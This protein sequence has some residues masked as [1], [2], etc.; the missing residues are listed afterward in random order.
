VTLYGRNV[1]NEYATT[2]HVQ[3]VSD[4]VTRYVSDPRTYG[5]TFDY[6]YD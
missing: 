3:V 6:K 5:I 2:G 1:F 4:I